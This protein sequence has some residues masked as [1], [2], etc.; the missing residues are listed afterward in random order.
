[1]GVMDLRR[2]I[3]LNE[4]HIVTTTPA[5]IA[6]FSTDMISPLKSCKVE[7]SPVQSGSGDPSPDN[8][9]PISGWT[10]CNVTR[11]GKN[12]FDINGDTSLIYAGVA[13]QNNRIV[14]S[15]I[16]SGAT[17][18][19]YFSTL[20]KPGT[21]TFS[22]KFSGDIS[23]IRV[24]SPKPFTGGTYNSYYG[25]YFKELSNGSVTITMTEQFTIGV[26]AQG[27]AGGQGVVYDLQLE[28][29]STATSYEPYTGTTIP[30]DWTT[31][32]GTVY[33][34]YVDLVSGE[35]VAEYR[36]VDLGDTAWV[37][38]TNSGHILF[39][40]RLDDGSQ[41]D[42]FA[43]LCSQYK[44]RTGSGAF[45]TD[46][47]TIRFYGS[48]VYNFSRCAVRDDSKANMTASEFQTAMTGVQ[49]VY[50][51]ATSQLIATLTPTQLKSLRG[52]NN[53]WSDANGDTTVKYWTH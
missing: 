37:K 27:V 21:Y 5:G 47:Y 20:Y 15:S 45:L 29:G 53:I 14:I 50:K 30:I 34:G 7:F 39:Y 19:V 33:G 41:D 6:N 31:E 40:R 10:G 35:L 26:I 13:I 44:T 4:P 32:A 24:F 3:M 28:L 2:R 17:S 51:L 52:V 1:M 46:D 12:L 8:V 38:F 43:G 42:D 48:T 23:N 36:F 18:R 25:G 16:G 22:G 11:C 9:R 49:A